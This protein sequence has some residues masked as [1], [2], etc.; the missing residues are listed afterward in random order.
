MLRPVRSE[1]LPV[2][3]EGRFSIRDPAV[4]AVE[5]SG[6]LPKAFQ[7]AEIKVRVETEIGRLP[8]PVR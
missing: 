1:I 6:D 4:R 7:L 5:L 8:G 3:C 2:E